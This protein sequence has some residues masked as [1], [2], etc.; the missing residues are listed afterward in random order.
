MFV[1]AYDGLNRLVGAIEVR[2]DEQIASHVA[3]GE[4][5]LPAAQP[6]ADFVAARRL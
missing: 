2:D 1:N 4:A 3:A 5:L 6:R